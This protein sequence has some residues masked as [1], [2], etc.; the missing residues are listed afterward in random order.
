MTLKCLCMALSPLTNLKWPRKVLGWL[1]KV[2]ALPRNVLEWHWMT[3]KCPWMTSISPWMIL[4]CTWMNF[5]W[6]C[7]ALGLPWYVLEWPWY[8][9]E[10]PWYVLGWLRNYLGI[11]LDDLESLRIFFGCFWIKVTLIS[12]GISLMIREI[13]WRY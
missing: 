5:K 8:V 1:W 9:L 4:I 3:L 2:L 13:H 6:P 7:Y 11:S 12:S 10:Y